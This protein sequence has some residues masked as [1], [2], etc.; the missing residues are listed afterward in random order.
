MASK[1]TT[2]NPNGLA[3]VNALAE[4]K[5][6]VLAFAEIAHLAGM[7][8]KTGYLT[9]EKKIASDRKLKI[10]KVEGGVKAK[11]HTATTY[12]SGLT[13]EADREIEIDGYRLSDAE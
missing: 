11:T 8:A 13:V 7:E 10:E 6:E 1:N 2:P 12:P 3:I 9:S 5:G 4:H